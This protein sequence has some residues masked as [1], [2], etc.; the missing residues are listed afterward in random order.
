M[1]KA[2]IYLGLFVGLCTTFAACTKDKKNDTYYTYLPGSW[3]L[4]Q[5]GVDFNK[6]G[7]VDS[8]EVYD[9]GNVPAVGSIAEFHTDFTGKS[10]VYFGYFNVSTGFNWGLSDFQKTLWIAKGNDTAKL[11]IT[12]EGLNRMH[13]LNTTITVYGNNTWMVFDRSLDK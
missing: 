6:N 4:V 8:G 10:Q 11:K 7:V 2:I 1:K 13:L 5:T 3:R 9:I 12:S